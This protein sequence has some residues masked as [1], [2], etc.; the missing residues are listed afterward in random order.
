MRGCDTFYTWKGTQFVT[1]KYMEWS[2]RGADG[3]YMATWQDWLQISTILYTQIHETPIFLQKMLW[4]TSKFWNIIN[5]EG[6]ECGKLAKA[7]SDLLRSEAEKVIEIWSWYLLPTWG[8][9]RIKEKKKKKKQR[10]REVFKRRLLS[11]FILFW[12]LLMMIIE[13]PDGKTSQAFHRSS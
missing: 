6:R 1:G 11:Y 4:Q 5:L 7:K 13:I 10:E 9:N 12:W 2:E 8:K 3:P